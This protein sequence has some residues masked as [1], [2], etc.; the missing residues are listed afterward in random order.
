M[1]CPHLDSRVNVCVCVCECV[2]FIPVCICGNSAVSQLRP[3]PAAPL[4]SAPKH[5]NN[6][7]L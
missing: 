7:S 6:Q 5:N 2:C 4:V 1:Q 3:Y